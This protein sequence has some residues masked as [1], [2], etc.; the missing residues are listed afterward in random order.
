VTAKPPKPA[1]RPLPRAKAAEEAAAALAAAAAKPEPKGAGKAGA[2]PAEAAPAAAAPAKPAEPPK[3]ALRVVKAADVAD[4][5]CSALPI[6]PSA[7]RP[8]KPR[9][10]AIREMMNAPKK[11]LVAKKPEEPP[12]PATK[13]AIKGTIHKKAGAPG[14]PAG[15]HGRRCQAG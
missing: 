5:R 8:P 10:K 12:K 14:A 2:A 11:V 4:E 15:D 3:P 1:P 9:P 7:A 6:W 13:E